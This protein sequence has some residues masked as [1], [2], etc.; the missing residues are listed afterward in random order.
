MI[1][2]TA[3]AH[4]PQSFFI[5]RY[6]IFSVHC[7]WRVQISMRFFLNQWFE[8]MLPKS[9]TPI[10]TSDTMSL[11]P[12]TGNRSWTWLSYNVFLLNLFKFHWDVILIWHFLWIS[13]AIAG[14]VSRRELSLFSLLVLQ[15][16]IT[17][18]LCFHFLKIFRRGAT[19]ILRMPAVL[20][21]KGFVPHSNDEY[22]AISSE[23]SP[24]ELLFSFVLEIYIY[25]DVCGGLRF[26]SFGTTIVY[27]SRCTHAT[28]GYAGSWKKVL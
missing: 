24:F 8:L 27:Y 20:M 5:S 6:S 25:C 26:T 17:V 19:K 21:D 3:K 16:N 22:T 14:V 18:F 10:R 15:V 1:W 4:T 23:D 2:A 11:C 9:H 28:P 12:P 7:S 13:K